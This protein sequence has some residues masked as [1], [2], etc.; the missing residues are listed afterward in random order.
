MYKLLIPAIRISPCYLNHGMLKE[1]QIEL[2]TSFFSY[3]LY[4]AQ[5]HIQL[6]TIYTVRT[7]SLGKWQTTTSQISSLFVPMIV[8]SGLAPNIHSESGSIQVLTLRSFL[9]WLLVLLTHLTWILTW[10]IHTTKKKSESRKGCV[11]HRS[12]RKWGNEH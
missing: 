11:M 12:Q 10:A 1:C 4:E 6:T 8:Y 3:S 2:Q 7:F 5:S 9:S